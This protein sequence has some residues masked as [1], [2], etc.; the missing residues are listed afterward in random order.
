M[1][2]TL[3][4]AALLNVSRSRVLHLIA[5]GRLPATKCGRDWFIWPV[6]LNCVKVRVNGRPRKLTATSSQ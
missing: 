3:E 6:D 5:A 1:L 4:A 2:T